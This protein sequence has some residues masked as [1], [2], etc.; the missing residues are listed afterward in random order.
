MFVLLLLHTTLAI[1]LTT[2]ENFQ[3]EFD[4]KC[5]DYFLLQSETEYVYFQ[6]R[7]GNFELWYTQGD[8]YSLYTS[9][10][11]ELLI[12]QWPEKIIN[13]NTMDLVLYEGS[14]NNPGVLDTEF[15]LCDVKGLVAGSMNYQETPCEAIKCAPSNTWKLNLLGYC[16][17]LL[18]L[19]L[20]GTNAYNET[21]QADISRMFSRVR[22]RY[23]TSSLGPETRL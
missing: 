19:L 4:S 16:I 22:R 11:T 12:F 8:N 15:I 7:N 18:M 10:W 13:N 6:N 9:P 3:V 5:R 1:N 20:F 23:P 2:F 21:I 17:G 14:I